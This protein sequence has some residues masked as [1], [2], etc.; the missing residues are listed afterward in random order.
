MKRIKLTKEEKR[1]EA[2]L[3]RGEY[4]VASSEEHRVIAAALATRKKDTVLNLRINSHD[5]Q[6]IKQKADSLGIRYQ[7]F[8]SEILHRV[9]ESQGSASGLQFFRLGSFQWPA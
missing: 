8:I 7:S 9:A 6:K 2:E 4:V 1:I 3:A 5:L